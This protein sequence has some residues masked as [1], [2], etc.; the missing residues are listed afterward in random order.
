MTPDPVVYSHHQARC[1]VEDALTRVDAYE[2]H[3]LFAGHTA[4]LTAASLWVSAK[5]ALTALREHHSELEAE[6]LDAA[7][8][9]MT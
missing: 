4:D 1:D 3:Y 8:E 7:V 2:R 9:A 5:T 6:A